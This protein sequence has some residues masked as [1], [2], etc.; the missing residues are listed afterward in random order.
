MSRRRRP[1][2]K[3]KNAISDQRGGTEELWDKPPVV[4]H[5][6]QYFDGTASRRK[7]PRQEVLR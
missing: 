1:Q 3:A 4:I 6:A 5:A 7:T 2:M